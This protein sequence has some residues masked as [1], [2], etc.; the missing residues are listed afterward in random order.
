MEVFERNVVK[1]KI[2]KIIRLEVELFE[3][4][5]KLGLELLGDSEDF[6]ELR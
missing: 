5:K 1:F 3:K 2:K 6:F 4:K